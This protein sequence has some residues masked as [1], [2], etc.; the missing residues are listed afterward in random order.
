MPTFKKGKAA[1]EAS[2]SSGGS[3]KKTRAN[4]WVNFFNLKDGESSYVHFVT[5]VEDLVPVGI[6]RMVRVAERND[7]GEIVPRWADFIDRVPGLFDDDQET[8]WQKVMHDDIQHKPQ[9]KTCGLAFILDPVYKEGSKGTRVADIESLVLRGRYWT[10]QEGEEIFFPEYQIVFQSPYT[11]WKPLIGHSEEV[12][13]INENSFKIIRQGGDTN[14]AYLP[15]E[16]KVPVVYG[17][18]D[19]NPTDKEVV[20]SELQTP[21]L[22][23]EL[24][25]LGTHERYEHYFGDSTLWQKQEFFNRPDDLV[26]ETKN[27]ADTKEAA[28]AFEQLKEKAKAKA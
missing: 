8:D 23:D 24:E 15:V 6:H 18:K 10:S 2:M 16:L 19:G 11:F 27:E 28:S 9:Y 12:G 14:T 13:P 21:S 25:K 1:I 22:E 4:H 20:W 26:D 5:D 7:K 17:D 3:K